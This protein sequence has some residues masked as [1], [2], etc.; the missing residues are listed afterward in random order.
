MTW[1]LERTGYASALRSRDLRLLLGGLVVSATG[2][3]AYNVALLVFVFDQTGSLTWV[4]LAG[5]ARF[6]P[7]LLLSTYGGVIAERFERVRVMI[8]A[9]LLCMVWQAL[10]AIVMIAE[11]PVELALLF[12]ALT[13]STNV[14]Y[15]PAVAAMLPE[16]VEDEGDLAAANAL[17]GT[18][19]NLVVIVG[20]AIG[21]GLV[22]LVSP[23]AAVIV[24]A[25]SFG[26]SALLVIRMRARS[27]PSDVTEGGDA[28]PLAQMAAGVRAIVSSRSV[29]L[30][31]GFCALVS[32]VYGTDTV[33]FVGVSESR[34]GTGADG[35][36]YL[37]AG[38]GLGGILFAATVNK[39]ASSPRLGT[40][41][42]LGTAF[43]CLP[44]ALLTVVTEPAVAFFIE[45][46]RGG[47]TI[48][49]DVIAVTAL[50]RSVAP[51]MV[52]RV[53]GVFFAV[54][55]GAI[56]LGTLITPAVV[57]ATSLDAGLWVMS[58]GPFALGLLGYPALLAIDRENA[59]RVA[60]LAPR[61]AIL[62]SL[63][64]F[65]AANRPVLERLA[66]AAKEIR[67]SAGT[68]IVTQGE[69]A[70]ALYVLTS[71]SVDVS[72]RGERG[73][74]DEFIRTM[75]P[76]SYFG[77]IGLLEGIPRTATVTAAEDCE[78]LRIAG[79]DFLE[80]LTTTPASGT[81]VDSARLRLA[82]THPSREPSFEPGA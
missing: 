11:A 39:L 42:L 70:D 8:A 33:L 7:A 4:G 20:P 69:A 44:T 81:L 67:A 43:Y 54:V 57:S 16:V 1:L 52:A 82:R 14:V 79:D 62:E 65:A 23:G 21:A 60:E 30:L 3:W 34:L 37:L 29:G 66:G 40:I 13:A 31:V 5:L 78:L 68:A 47:G 2:S 27:R 77:E 6:V 45:V 36:G 10:L 76:G 56:S 51:E 26:V 25:A 64:I 49:V 50:Q 17:N 9:D 22:A 75:E 71:G 63:G 19:E 73:A 32:F 72:S 59:A 38:L 74:A 61:I 55:L 53:F 41:I 46:V 15:N 28:G 24:D 35:F 48:V 58:V 12:A 80:S 18:I